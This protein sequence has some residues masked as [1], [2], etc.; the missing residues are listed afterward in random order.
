[1]PHK[2][3]F[4]PQELKTLDAAYHHA[5]TKLLARHPDKDIATEEDL[6]RKITQLAS[7]GVV[8]PINLGDLALDLLAKPAMRPPC[9]PSG[10]RVE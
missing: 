4:N 9:D 1:M 8:D 6:R 2:R 3:S 5:L 7:Y 10:N